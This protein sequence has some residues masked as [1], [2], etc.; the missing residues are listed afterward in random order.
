MELDNKA[1]T[2]GQKKSYKINKIHANLG[3]AVWPDLEVFPPLIDFCI[4]KIRVFLCYSFNYMKALVFLL[5]NG[6]WICS[7]LLKN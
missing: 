5:G 6:L 7:N 2:Q 4:N 3:S 1:K